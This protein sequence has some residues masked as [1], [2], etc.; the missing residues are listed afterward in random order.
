M[1]RRD[2]ICTVLLKIT[3]ELRE[4]RLQH[5]RRGVSVAGHTPIKLYGSTGLQAGQHRLIA[6]QQWYSYA[7]ALIH[8]PFSIYIACIKLI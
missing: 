8:H 3:P 2:K 5:A 4:G 1:L 7:A 6:V